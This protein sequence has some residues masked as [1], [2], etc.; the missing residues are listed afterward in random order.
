MVEDLPEVIEYDNPYVFTVNGETFYGISFKGNYREK[1]FVE[2]DEETKRRASLV[3]RDAFEFISK[4]VDPQSVD[5]FELFDLSVR[6]CKLVPRARH[7]LGEVV[8]YV[9]LKRRGYIVRLG[10]GSKRLAIRLCMELDSKPNKDK[11]LSIVF[12]RASGGDPSLYRALAVV[13]SWLKKRGVDTS[14][15]LVAHMVMRIASV[16]TKVP[17]TEMLSRARIM[18]AARSTLSKNLRRLGIHLS[19]V[20]KKEVFPIDLCRHLRSSGIE[21]PENVACIG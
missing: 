11:I 2:P 3:Y 7:V 5:R 15:H 4:Y 14:I 6:A 8:G 16:V 19:P 13:Y 21:I 10:R 18:P 1:M 9:Y 12:S 20:S 17:T